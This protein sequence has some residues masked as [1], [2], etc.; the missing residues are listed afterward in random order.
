MWIFSFGPEISPN[1]FP[2]SEVRIPTRIDLPGYTPVKKLLIVLILTGLVLAGVAWWISTPKAV[3]IQR[4][5]FSYAAAVHGDIAETVS[6]TGTLKPR[7]GKLLEIHSQVPGQVVEL[8]HGI[9]D[10]VK[11]GDVLLTLYDRQAKL[12]LQEAEDN[13]VITEK[14]IEQAEAALTMAVKA[15]EYQK[16]I[17]D[18]DMTY[19]RFALEKAEGEKK[20]A[21]AALEVARVK[22]DSARTQRDKAT[23]AWEQT[24]IKVP[25]ATASAT[26]SAPE[27]R[28]LILERKV[29]LGQMV[30]PQSPLPLFVLAGDLTEMEIHTQVVE[31]DISRIKKKMEALFSLNSSEEE[32]LYHGQV[33]EIFPLPINDRGAVYYNAIIDAENQ[34]NLETGEWHLRPGMTTSVDFVLRKKTNVWKIPVAAIGFQMADEYQSPNARE[35]IADWKSRSD[36]S[37]W[38]P[39]WIWQEEPRR[40][41]P[42]LVR[43]NDPQTNRAGIQDGEFHEVLEWEPGWTPQDGG[44]GW[45][46]ITAAPPPVEPGLFNQ[47]MNLKVS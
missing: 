40:V 4:D 24:I 21:A 1:A 15:H 25:E 10:I 2:F 20:V 39:V 45:R 23:E 5:T 11:P 36:W 35:K 38:Q 18:M 44:T 31:G 17:K 47:P 42:I 27:P 33:R 19:S 16:E 28:Y 43:L 6:A 37:D 41:W 12:T 8:A 46:L 13:V 14:L 32:D 7:T 34:K 9:N 29:T 3:S 26:I 22:L 30:S